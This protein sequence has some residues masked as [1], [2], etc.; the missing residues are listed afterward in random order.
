MQHV[1]ELIATYASMNEI[2]R[3]RLRSIA[4]RYAVHWPINPR[5][6]PLLSLV[7]KSGQIQALDDIVNSTIDDLAAIRLGKAVDSDDA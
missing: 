6:R 3:Q 2:G 7:K 1:S 4:R 5:Q